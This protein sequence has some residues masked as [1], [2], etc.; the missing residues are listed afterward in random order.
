MINEI[1]LSGGD[2]LPY[3]FRKRGVGK[4][5]GSRTFGG[6]VG[7]WL[8]PFL[9]DGGELLV[10]HEGSFESSDA[11]AIEGHGVEPD[12]VVHE[13]PSELAEGRDPQLEAAVAHL[14]KELDGRQRPPTPRPP[15]Q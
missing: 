14:L 10:P 13:T 9:V 15:G 8:T 5:V 6:M 1:S 2:S 11:W 12:I 4:L 7:V 3:F